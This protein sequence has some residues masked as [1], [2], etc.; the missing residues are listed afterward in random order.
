MPCLR[1]HTAYDSYPR[2]HTQLLSHGS[3]Y[4]CHRITRLSYFSITL[5]KYPSGTPTHLAA[6]FTTTWY[7]LGKYPI[8]S[9]GLYTV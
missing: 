5:D 9:L 4:F 8:P 1:A 2:R 6:L 3:Y 7:L